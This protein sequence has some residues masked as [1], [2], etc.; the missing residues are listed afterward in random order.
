MT[1]IDSSLPQAGNFIQVN[2][3]EL[4]YEDYGSG[5]PLTPAARWHEHIANLA[6]IPANFHSPF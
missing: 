1:D 3:L 4:Y 5:T 2:G 6:G